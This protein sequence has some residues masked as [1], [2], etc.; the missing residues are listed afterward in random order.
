MRMLNFVETDRKVLNDKIKAFLQDK[1]AT[2]NLLNIQK[3]VSY[4]KKQYL[5]T[6]MYIDKKV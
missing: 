5:A 6:V 4:D 1:G 3:N 2:I